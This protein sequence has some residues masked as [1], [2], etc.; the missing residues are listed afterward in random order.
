VKP[1]RSGD[2]RTNLQ[3]FPS[4]R[5]VATDLSLRALVMQAWRLQM[6]EVEGGPDWIASDRLT[7]LQRRPKARRPIRF[8]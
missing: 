5:F 8:V 4:G 2:V 7:L 6:F 3:T 1:N